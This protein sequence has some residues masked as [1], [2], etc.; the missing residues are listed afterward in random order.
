MFEDLLV[1]FQ[2]VNDLFGE[3]AIQ[4]LKMIEVTLKGVS[5]CCF[6]CI[7]DL[8]ADSLLKNILFC[9]RSSRRAFASSALVLL[10]LL[11]DE[12]L[13]LF[14]VLVF[15]LMCVMFQFFH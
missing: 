5:I 12:V 9:V 6:L 13:V 8:R 15:C 10:L 7:R 1:A 14:S 2:Q 11:F 4:S 3:L